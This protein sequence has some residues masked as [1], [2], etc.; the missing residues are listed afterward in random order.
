MADYTY[1]YTMWSVARR[2]RWIAALLLALAIAATFAA[3]SQ[4][5][6]ARSVQNG[7]PL[8]RQ[9]ETVSELAAITK[10][11]APVTDKLDGQLVETTGH[12]TADDFM[13]VADRLNNGKQGWWVIGHFAAD[14]ASGSTAGLAVAV[15]WAPT[16]KQAKSARTELTR[17]TS[18]SA[19]AEN[20][21]ISGRYNVGD[22]PSDSDYKHNR[23][24]TVSA[25]ALLN[26][27]ST[28]DS[29]GVYGGYLTSAKPSAGLTTIYSPAPISTVQ[30]DLLN[31]F[32]AVE[33]VVFA[34]F[35]IF[36]WYR[37]VRDAW[38][39][40]REEALEAAA[41]ASASASAEQV[42]DQRAEVN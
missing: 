23:L 16:E 28:S 41:E 39:R 19:K 40:E 9:T 31:V 32:Y 27:W 1:P 20:L 33:W 14:T 13:L 36:L 35:A 37:L 26:E 5:Q 30:V 4:W 29:A 42:S 17:S 7:T 8:V 3:L 12:W 2:P 25:A 38:E 6:L 21:T 24:T 34:G 11:Q 18:A 15:G 10:P 22:A